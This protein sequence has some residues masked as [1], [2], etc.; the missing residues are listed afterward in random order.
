MIRWPWV[1][2][3]R[4][5]AAEAGVKFLT[6]MLEQRVRDERAHHESSM[7]TF[8]RWFQAERERAGELLARYH[9]L[10]QQG[11]VEPAPVTPREA[12]SVDPVKRAIA[13]KAG[14]NRVLREQMEAQVVVDRLNG[15]SEDEIVMQIMNGV[16]GTTEAGLMFT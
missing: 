15:K 13:Q 12:R 3:A 2:R 1:S 9:S 7:A 14:P 5:E 11:Y 8:D 16:D 4:L 6:G 10:K